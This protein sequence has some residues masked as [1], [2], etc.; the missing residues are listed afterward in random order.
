MNETNE[1]PWRKRAVAA[2][3]RKRAVAAPWRAGS[4]RKVRGAIEEAPRRAAED[5]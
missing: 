3:W 5:G 4:A 1:A 2:P